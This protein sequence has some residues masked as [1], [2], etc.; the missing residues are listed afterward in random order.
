VLLCPDG[1]LVCDRVAEVVATSGTDRIPSQPVSVVSQLRC[2]RRVGC[3]PLS[4]LSQCR[5]ATRYTVQGRTAPHPQRVSQAAHTSC[6][7]LLNAAQGVP[8]LPLFGSNAITT[9][10]KI[11]E[12]CHL[13]ADAPAIRQ[14]NVPSGIVQKLV[15]FLLF[16]SIAYGVR[17]STSANPLSTSVDQALG[18]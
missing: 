16:F 5:M 4:P 18:L 14:G 15:A 17:Y 10:G 6:F 8:F 7:H 2:D 12:R 1:V 13:R 3:R 9:S 11:S